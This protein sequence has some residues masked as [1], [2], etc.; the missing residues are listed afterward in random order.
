MRLADGVTGPVGWARW[1][2]PRTGAAGPL[3]PRTSDRGSPWIPC[4]VDAFEWGIQH[5][6][7]VRRFERGAKPRGLPTVSGSAYSATVRDPHDGYEEV[8]FGDDARPSLWR[9]MLIGAAVACLVIALV[10]GLHE[11]V[12]ETAADANS[13][14]ASAD[15]VDCAT[16]LR[17]GFLSNSPQVWRDQWMYLV[18]HNGQ[19]L[20]SD[21]AVNLVG[22]IGELAE[23]DR[24]CQPL[25][26]F[27]A[28]L[29]RIEGLTSAGKRIPRRYIVETA[30]AGDAWL[31]AS[32]EK[33]VFVE[34]SLDSPRKHWPWSS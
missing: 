11:S 6:L 27:H 5:V 17:D 18:S 22:S 21:M 14:A 19:A 20:A 34:G 13:S 2:T 9:R 29:E 26:A 23:A 24:K 15:S 33:P 3:P 10:S 32:N 16:G 1:P 30:V 12:D 28:H 4:P 8:S 31:I 25:V 7:E